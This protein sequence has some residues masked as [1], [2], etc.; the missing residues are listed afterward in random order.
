[1]FGNKKGSGNPLMMLPQLKKA[2]QAIDEAGE[3][4]N[5]LELNHSYH[6]EIIKMK[7]KGD[8]IIGINLTNDKFQEILKEDPETAEDLV[9]AAINSVR[10]DLSKKRAD[11]IVER[12][13]TL[14]VPQNIIDSMSNVDLNGMF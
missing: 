2:Q 11:L 4:F 9:C 13:K 8:N 10:S 1:M 12:A 3:K 7:S 14:K 5:T 6:N